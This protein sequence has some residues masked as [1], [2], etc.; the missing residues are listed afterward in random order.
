MLSSFIFLLACGEKEPDV[1]VIVDDSDTD[2]NTPDCDRDIDP[3]CDGFTRADGDCDPNDGLVYPGATEI[4][5][6]GKD[7]DCAGDGDW[8]DVDEDGFV[9]ASA[10]GDDC[11]DSNPE[12]Y[13]GAEEI[14][15]DGIDQ[16]CAG[17]VELENNNDCDGDGFQ[18]AAP[19]LQTVMTRT[20]LLILKQKKFGMMERIRTA[21]LAR[22]MI[23]MVTVMPSQDRI[24][25]VM[26]YLMK[27]VIQTMMALLIMWPAQIV[28]T[29]IR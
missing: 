8:N 24:V 11:D 5:Y 19:M 17:D 1:P 18:V 28:T 3:D 2:T 15:Y 27:A 29:L 14:C 4:P 9:G 7:N 10:G 12:V 21:M 20:L 26:A 25:T 13:P 6:D 22:T 16:D 23:K